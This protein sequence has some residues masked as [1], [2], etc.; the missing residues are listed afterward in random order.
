MGSTKC[1]RGAG[2]VSGGDT[3]EDALGL[4]TKEGGVGKKTQHGAAPCATARDHRG[5]LS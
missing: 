1:C 3:T 4:L 2:C 5:V